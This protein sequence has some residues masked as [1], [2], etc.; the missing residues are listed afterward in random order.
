MGGDYRSLNKFFQNCGINH[1]VSCP[2]TPQQ[3]G[4]VERKHHYLVETGLALSNHA[5]IPLQYWED[6]FQ[7]ACYLINRLPTSTIQNLSP[8][9][10]L[11]AQ[12]PNYN[13]LRVFGCACWPNLRPYNSH[14][15]QPRS[16]QC[17]FLGYSLLHKGYKCL[18]L[19]SGRVYFSRGVLFNEDVFPFARSC[20]TNFQSPSTSDLNSFLVQSSTKLHA[21]A[22]LSIGP[23][24]FTSA[25]L[26]FSAH[27]ESPQAHSETLASPQLLAHPSSPLPHYESLPSHISPPPSTLPN[28]TLDDGTVSPA[29]KT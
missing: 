1:H 25:T 22:P 8:Y 19:P 9:E 3:N 14:K 23:P 10:K 24:P 21:A 15:L 28:N 11:F 12:A 6:A 20:S 4:V 18:H 29:P 13:F 27:N 16:T 7:T 5:H 26:T 17:V 2:H